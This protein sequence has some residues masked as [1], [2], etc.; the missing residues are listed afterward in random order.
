MP[1]GRRDFFFQENFSDL[2]LA[3][4]QEHQECVRVD[5]F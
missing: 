2:S 3:K 1:G 4:S 5:L